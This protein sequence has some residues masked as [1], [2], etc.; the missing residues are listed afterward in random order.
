MLELKLYI[1][2]CGTVH[3]SDWPTFVCTFSSYKKLAVDVKVGSQILCADG[4]IVFEVLETNPKEGSV[5]CKCCN[6][7]SLGYAL[8]PCTLYLGFLTSYTGKW[9]SWTAWV[10]NYCT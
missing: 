2:G 5:Q 4:S 1:L 10:L 3:G 7:A 6:N 8:K 9:E